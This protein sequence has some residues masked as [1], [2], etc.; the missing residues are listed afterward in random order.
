MTTQE[1]M[2]HPLL[3]LSGISLIA[4]AHDQAS[5]GTFLV[6]VVLGMGSLYWWHQQLE[7]CLK[8]ASRQKVGPPPF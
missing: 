2:P 5:F 3:L 7:R 8:E 4:V 1:K 6:L